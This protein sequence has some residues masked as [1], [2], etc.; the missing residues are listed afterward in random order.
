MKGSDPGSARQGCFHSRVEGWAGRPQWCFSSLA[1]L[2]KKCWVSTSP[3][4]RSKGDVGSAARYK[5]RDKME[6]TE[7]GIRTGTWP[8]SLCFLWMT[9]S[10]RWVVFVW[11][12]YVNNLSCVFTLEI[13]TDS[14]Y[15]RPH[16]A[17]EAT[18]SW[19]PSLESTRSHWVGMLS[20]VDNW[21][22]F[23]YN[24]RSRHPP[25]PTPPPPQPLL[26]LA[27][28]LKSCSNILSVSKL[29][30]LGTLW[31]WLRSS[32]KGLHNIIQKQKQDPGLI[33][34]S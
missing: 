23:G 11:L 24:T 15:F 26:N 34:Y 33:N 32:S 5:I 12:W 2:R 28:C 8:R 14:C 29:E 22:P 19:N 7:P 21:E 13:F 10:A 31:L 20:F 16:N 1:D 17:H 9:Q 18:V 3:D 27:L 25:P 4:T 6:F 30:L